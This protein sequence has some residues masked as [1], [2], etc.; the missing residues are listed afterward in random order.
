MRAVNSSFCLQFRGIFR[1]VFPPHCGEGW[2]ETQILWA[3]PLL[4]GGPFRR[5]GDHFN[6][7]NRCPWT[8]YRY[9]SAS[10]AT[11]LSHLPLSRHTKQL[12]ASAKPLLLVTGM[13]LLWSSSFGSNHVCVPF[14]WNCTRCFSCTSSAQTVFPWLWLWLSR[15]AQRQKKRCYW[16]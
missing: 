15:L 10:P 7:K 11:F 2:N 8:I 16:S 14:V 5:L 9:L 1:A 6:C 12:P 3:W 13:S 4:E